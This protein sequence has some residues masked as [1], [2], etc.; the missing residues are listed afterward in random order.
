MTLQVVA[1]GSGTADD[2]A[3]VAAQLAQLPAAIGDALAAHKIKVVACRVSVTDFAKRLKGVHPR[4]WPEGATWDTVPGAYLP[5]EQAVA[6]ATIQPADGSP[7]RVPRDGEGHGSRSLAVHETMHG[8]DYA[9]NR[10][11]SGASAFRKVW[12]DECHAH[13]ITDAY[14]TD[15][16]AGPEET[17]AE[18]AAMHFGLDPA[19]RSKWPLFVPFWDGF[20]AAPPPPKKKSGGLFGGLFGLAAGAGGG[21]RTRPK[22][23]A[24]GSG[25]LLANG[26]IELNVTA[27]NDAG[28]HGH[29][30][31]SY[32][33]GDVHYG[34]VRAHVLPPSAGLGMAGPAPGATF[35]VRPF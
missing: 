30:M 16:N 32:A 8:Y 25:R 20:V 11:R 17:Y 34:T 2:V 19:D 21:A 33:Q 1:G 10:D 26:T 35:V 4:N 9:F 23:A 22:G 6:I 18:S 27:E 12:T 5:T 28:D 29:A 24:I 31:L 15:A 13:V 3:L 14:F 7:R